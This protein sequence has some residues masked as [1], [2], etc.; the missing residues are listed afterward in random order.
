MVCIEP[1]EGLP[2]HTQSQWARFYFTQTNLDAVWI[3]S[4][5]DMFP[6]SKRYIVDVVS[7]ISDDCF[8]SLRSTVDHFPVCY[9]IA[10]GKVFQEIL[11]FS[12]SFAEDV[13]NVYEGTWTPEH[14]IDG[15]GSFSNWAADESYSSSKICKYRAEH[16]HKIVQLRL[17][18]DMRRLDRSYWEYNEDKVRQNLYLDCH[19]IRPY[20]LYKDEI[21]RL[22]ALALESPNV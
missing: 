1:V 16:P 17:P 2:I 11:Q 12:P 4:D 20:R 15:L 14:H 18:A 8:V 9:N 19:S 5:I 22:L 10:T 13:R 6:L 3:T 21:E 7:D